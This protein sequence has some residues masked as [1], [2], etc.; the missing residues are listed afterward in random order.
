MAELSL[1][2]R[3]SRLG[4]ESAFAVLKRATDLEKKGKEVIHLE[5]GQPDF[6]TPRH[7]IDAAYQAMLNGHTGYTTT[8]GYLE[9]REAIAKFYRE[10]KKIAANADEVVIV[11]GGK[12]IMFYVMLALIEEG[13]EVICPNPGFPIY[14]SCIRF[15]GG[16]PVPMPIL[17]ENEFKVD[18]EGLKKLL[19]DRTKLIIINSPANP[20]GGVLDKEDILKIAEIVRETKAFVLSDECYDRLIFDGSTPFSIASIEDMKERT[21]VLDA[22]SK[23][24]AM[25]GWR[26]GFGVMSRK[27]AE[28]VT[29]LMV[30]SNSCAAAFSQIAAISALE[31]PQDCVEQMRMAY[32][33]RLE[34]IVP[35]LNEI[36]GIEC[37]MPRGSF[38]A[39]PC[40]LGTGMDD[41]T[42][43][44]RLLNEA[45]VA[46]L[47]GSSFGEYGSGHIRISA[48]NSLENLKKAVV[49]I[50]QFVMDNRK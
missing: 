8:Q 48:A 44:D 5:I 23:T 17:Q 37:L 39:F 9:A 11:P 40:I 18:I 49:R 1:A 16:I 15:A 30:N 3:M 10:K 13:D 2:K 21:I 36:E 24:Y 34:Y 22:F 47:A 28:A 7:I 19:T 32:K 31:G 38:Y 4:S 50:K 35:A 14:E 26:L 12:P 25:T 42:F 20:T 45:G 29:L 27:M 6:K 46:V 43:A 41:K 33:E